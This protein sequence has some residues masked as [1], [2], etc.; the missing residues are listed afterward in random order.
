MKKSVASV[1]RL[2]EITD[3][4]KA[5]DKLETRSAGED[6]ELASLESEQSK[7]NKEY[8]EAATA[9]AKEEEEQQLHPRDFTQTPEVREKLELRERS[10]F[11]RF[12]G[13][14][15][16]GR[17]LN[18]AEVE[19]RDS[20]GIFDGIPMDLWEKDR[21]RQLEIRADAATVAAAAAS[22]AQPMAWAPFIFSDS[23]AQSEMNV[24]MPPAQ[25]GSWIEPGFSVA[26]SA[27]PK[28][29]GTAQDST[30]A[31]VTGLTAKPARIAARATI[32]L[33]DIYAIGSDGFEDALKQQARAALSDELDH[34]II[35]GNDS[36]ANL[37]GLINQLVDPSNPTAIATFEQFISGV[38]A[39]IDGKWAHSLKELRVLTHPQAYK[40]A[41]E[42]Y[43]TT[44]ST[45]SAATFLSRELGSW[46][47][48]SRMPAKV[49]NISKVLMFRSGRPGLK[50]AVLPSY[51][52]IQIDDPYTDAA[53]GQRHF[54]I[55]AIVGNKV[56]VTQ[57]E[58]Y[59]LAEFKVS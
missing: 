15:L 29:K 28:T 22:G 5:I 51:S 2:T 21:P 30:A 18:G 46:K 3:R 34:Q 45:E 40:L 8:R 49:S 9:E 37:N 14:A 20:L 36:G 32:Q 16:L 47:T 17:Q 23:I 4:L 25:S 57:A 41:L 10:R 26:L 59:K 1:M 27:D 13:S 6:T 31:T 43:R 48:S 54:T 56:L 58:A 42:K 19:Y 39:G 11:G 24:S 55:S 38:A 7:V 44:E 53:S 33:E 50:T 12:L 52:I 35:S